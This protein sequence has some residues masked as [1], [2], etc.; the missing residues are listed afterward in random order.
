MVTVAIAALGGVV[1]ALTLVD[2]LITGVSAG[3]GAGP[4]TGRIAH[5]TWRL[6]RRLQR[7]TGSTR[8][9]VAGG[10]LILV[11]VVLVWVALLILGWSLVFGSPDVLQTV[12]DGEG[13]AV[14]GLTRMRYAAT[15]IIGRG[16]SALQP[17][18]G[19]YE[20]LEPMA[21][22]SGLAVLSL[23]IAYVLPVV[24][25]VVEKRALAQYISTLGTTPAQVLRRAWNGEDLGDLHL[26]LIALVP[27]VGAVAQSHLAYPI[28]HFFHSAER[29]T[30]LGPSIVALD[31]AIT[32]N[33][34][35]VD[36]VA[37]KKTAIKPLRHAVSDFLDTLHLAF[38]EPAD[39]D[40][41]EGDERMTATLR[42]LEEEGIPLAAD[43][44]FELSEEEVRRNRL[45][46]G[47]LVHDGWEDADALDIASSVPQQQVDDLAVDDDE[48]RVDDIEGVDRPDDVDEATAGDDAGS[49]AAS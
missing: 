41:A 1:I 30:A 15:I 42:A 5:T 21:A 48:E 27:R 22:L 9:L 4:L 14:P 18:G 11:M 31:E 12:T 17:V 23:S 43:A 37:V 19:L 10:P 46:R 20:I 13:T 32:A 44:R 40:V 6:L 33:G 38:I 7:A 25:G 39:V 2:L 34:L 49:P 35:L 28:I 16:S 8:P 29:R 3:R 24:R 36:E 45:L 26:H 47:Y